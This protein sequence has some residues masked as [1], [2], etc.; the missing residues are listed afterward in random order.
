VISVLILTL[1][2]EVNLHRC[3]ESVRWS[4]DVVVLD[5]FSTDRT[6]E[7]AK[8][9][10]VR[11]V[12]R[13]FDNWSAHQ[14]WALQ[15]IQF[16]HPWVY[17]S[18][19]DEVV[20]PE[21]R[22]EML[23]TVS[24]APAGVAAYRLRYKNYFMGRWIRHCGIYPVWILRLFRP[25]KVRWER[26]V[27]PVPVI[28]G[29]EGKLQGHFAHYSFNKGMNAWFEKHNR[30][31]WQEAE[32]GVKEEGRRKKEEIGRQ[33]SGGRC[34]REAVMGAD[35]VVRRQALKELSFRLPCR[36]LLRFVYMYFLRLG[37]L[38]GLPGYHYCRLLA[39]YEYM[40]VLKMK[41]IRRRQRGFQL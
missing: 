16:K 25:E 28:Q 14:N 11:V 34:V 10:G 1:D 21:L 6:L 36:P 13:R 38:D 22:D 2:E 26:L 30:Y 23:A 32:E 29:D 39:I 19:A 9:A 33:K 20:T 37:F 35:P 4:D 41:E 3:L 31:S 17:Y 18:D 40:I 12:Q 24:K 27:N 7:I 5:S 8:A 15:N